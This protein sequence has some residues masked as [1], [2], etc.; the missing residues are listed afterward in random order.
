MGA[1]IQQ[2]WSRGIQVVRSYHGSQEFKLGGTPWW[3]D[4][5]QGA[6]SRRLLGSLLAGLR[7][8][9]W[10]VAASLDISRQ[11]EDKTILVLR[12]SADTAA[13]P[14]PQKPGAVSQ[15]VDWACLSFHEVDKIR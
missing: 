12:Q 5:D 6:E 4:G 11:M 9:G 15:M 10:E 8:G 3:A 13:A 1:V 14:H 7:W 2:T